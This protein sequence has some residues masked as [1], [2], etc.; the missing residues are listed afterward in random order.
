MPFHYHNSYS[1]KSWFL[2]CNL[3]Y[4]QTIE[5]AQYNVYMIRNCYLSRYNVPSLLP[6]DYQC[7]CDLRKL[8]QCHVGQRYLTHESDD[9]RWEGYRRDRGHGDWMELGHKGLTKDEMVTGWAKTR[10]ANAAAGAASGAGA[11][12]NGAAGHQARG[13]GGGS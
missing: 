7:W 13:G 1:L 8:E 11:V 9:A 6:Q 4:F 12:A 2:L 5:F 3:K 10:T